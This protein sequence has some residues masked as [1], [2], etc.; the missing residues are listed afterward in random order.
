MSDRPDAPAA[1]R[2][3][4]AILQVLRHELEGELKVLEIGSGTGQHAIHFAEGLPGLTWQTSD[5]AQNHDGIRQWIASSGLGNVLDP[6]LLDVSVSADSADL[7]T[8]YD[9][10][11]SANTAHIM[12]ADSV[13]DMVDLVG[14]LLTPKGRFLLYG[15]FRTDHQ[16]STESNRRFDQSLKAQDPAMGIR[17]LEWIDALAA[18]HDMARVS[19]YAMPANNMLLVW[20][21]GV[22]DNDDDS[23]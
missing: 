3:R 2:N 12:S 13:V 10:I 7:D 21:K 8:G 14:R 5:R 16:F 15:P 1:V 9:A 17:D 18:S 20:E 6:I 23:S 4:D 11:F 22:E 19:T